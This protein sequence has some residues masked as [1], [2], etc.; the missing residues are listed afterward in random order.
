MNVTSLEY[1]AARIRTICIGVHGTKIDDILNDDKLGDYFAARSK[2]E[3]VWKAA[4]CIRHLTS[5]K[6][7]IFL[8]CSKK[9]RLTAEQ[10]KQAGDLRV[11]LNCW[12]KSYSRQLGQETLEKEQQQEDLLITAEKATIFRNS[13]MHREAI[14][15]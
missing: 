11:Q 13:E 4:T 7:M 6:K 15:I 8:A 10:K 1:K 12:T 2:G 3:R 5:L 9:L 14:K